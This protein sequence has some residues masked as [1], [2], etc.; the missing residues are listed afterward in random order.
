MCLGR[1][2][3]MVNLSINLWSHQP[4]F[5]YY[6]HNISFIYIYLH[7]KN[8]EA[9]NILSNFLKANIKENFAKLDHF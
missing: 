7:G 9:C 8:F 4:N 3:D 1:S 6:M 2:V 5:D